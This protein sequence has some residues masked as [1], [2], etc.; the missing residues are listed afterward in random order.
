MLVLLNPHSAKHGWRVPNSLLTLGAYLEGKYDYEIVD[1]NIHKDVIGELEKV[2][3]RTG[4][5]YL[6]ITVM[7]GPQLHSSIPVSQKIKKLFPDIKIIWGGYFPTFHP[8]TVLRSDFVDYVIRGNAEVSLIELLDN[9]ENKIGAKQLS[10]IKGLSYRSGTEILHNEKAAITI[11]D[12]VPYLPYHKLPM[13]TYLRSAKTYVGERTIAYF[14]SIGCPFLCGFCAI[15]GFYKGTWLGRSP[16]LVYEHLRNLKEQYNIGSVEFFDDN[17]FV[18]EKRSYEIAKYIKELKLSWWA[19]ARPDTFLKFSDETFAMLRD[20]GLKMVFMG[21]ESG[22][23]ESLKM[24]N[25]G[26]TQTPDTMLQLAARMK[27]FDIV[28]EF[29]FVMGGPSDN[30]D[31]DIDN[32]ITYIRKLKK[33]NPA[34]E[35]IFYI[36]TPVKYEES[37]LSHM[38]KDKGFEYPTTLEEWESPEWKYFDVRRYAQTPWLKPRHVRKIK[39]FER[40]LNSYYPTV[41]DTKITGAKRKLMELLGAWRY[42]TSF[43]FAPYE[44]AVLQKL[45]RYRQPETEGFVFEN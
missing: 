8:N 1:E 12:E 31:R 37:N 20:S 45:L 27:K 10:E 4:A 26:G 38:A 44:L 9:L 16:E 24:M 3:R 23:A 18:S 39:D 29:S 14:S 35:I 36:Y 43:Y 11:P 22:S 6:G 28:P 17:F 30:V 13:E 21:A 25:K 42:K 40:T 2:I 34:T 7:P 15:A 5:R 19:E 41:T 32:E 33:I